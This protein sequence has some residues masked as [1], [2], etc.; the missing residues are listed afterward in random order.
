MSNVFAALAERL[1]AAAQAS[2]FAPNV[3]RRVA[4][5]FARLHFRLEGLP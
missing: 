3:I 2:R 1:F 5:M 4:T